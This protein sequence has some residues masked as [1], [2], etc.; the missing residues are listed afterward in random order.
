MCR[1]IKLYFVCLMA[2]MLCACGTG[3]SSSDPL[4]TDTI[5]VNASVTS[6][7]V[8]QGSLLT[9]TVTNAAGNPVTG[10][11]VSFAFKINNSGGTLSILN[12]ETKSD[13]TA[14]AS[15]TAGA[16]SAANSLEDTIQVSI[17]NGSTG[18]V[19]ITRSGIGGIF[20][21]K[22]EPTTLDANQSSVITATV[23]DN[24]GNPITG[25]T[26]D[27]SI[28]VG[29]SG[30]PGY[31]LPALTTYS[32][33]S[34]SSGIVTTIY[35][36]G[37]ALPTNKVDDAVQAILADGSNRV[38]VITR[39]AESVTPLS[40]SVLPDPNSVNAGQV[41]II[42]AT[43]TGDN[44]NGVTVTFSLPIN[45]TGAILSSSTAITDSVGKAVVIYQPG[46]NS[47]TLS[48]QD[49]VQAAV[50]SVTS[51][52]AITRIGSAT[53]GFS[54]AIIAT[55]GALLTR[56]GQSVV[57]ATVKNNAGVTVSGI[58]V[59][60]SNAGTAGGAV[61]PS[62]ATTDGSGNA[63]TTYTAAATAIST[64]TIVASITIDGNT[65]TA[66]VVIT[67]P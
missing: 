35:S 9:A 67:T 26:V 42:T 66:A 29:N 64:E 43:L 65:Y 20:T 1:C 32:G 38:V 31:R 19:V 22:A 57:R 12:N 17:S 48:V 30:S 27:F 39:K 52:A 58:K 61:S 37:N 53:S 47:P 3:A 15:Y 60:F 8:G 44:N 16:N 55:P 49:A 25:K 18:A 54:I 46:V 51:A 59:N 34:D 11:S 41:S 45:K 10:R 4:G 13:G 7:G 14:V 63:E 33:V 62:E 2:L 24:K 23:T 5:T 21:L 50:G 28:P 36:P 56:T 40:I 6:L